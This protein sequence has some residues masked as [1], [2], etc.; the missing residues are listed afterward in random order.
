[1]LERLVL[2]FREFRG[3]GSRLKSCKKGFT[4]SEVLITLGIVGVVAAIT[5][6][7][8]IQKHQEQVTVSKVKKFYSTMSQA[9]LFATKDNG[10]A[11]Q[12]EVKKYS[13]LGAEQFMSYLAPHLRILR[14]CGTSVGCL[15]YDRNITLLSGRSHD[16]NYEQNSNYYKFIL[17]DGSY[18]WLRTSY[19][20]TYCNDVEFNL[21][22]VCAALWID[23]NGQKLPNTVGRDIFVFYVLRDRIAMADAE[24]DLSSEGWGCTSYIIKNGNMDYLHKKN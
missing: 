4:L 12:W 20:N 16:T 24:C 18:G 22:N 1:M 17:N 19:Y 14:D 21:Q 5:M 23:V 7:T 11:E 8:L 3:E 15:K 6:P 13:K 10:T 9:F 2:L